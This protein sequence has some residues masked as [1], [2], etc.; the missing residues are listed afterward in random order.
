MGVTKDVDMEFTRWHDIS[1]VQVM[2]MNPNLIPHTVNIVIEEG[3]YELEFW[4][5]S[6]AEVTTTKKVMD[7]DRVGIMTLLIGRS[8]RQLVLKL[9]L[10]VL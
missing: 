8:R 10:V 9:A 4:V 3:F 6:N 7:P 2:V 1:R 5:E